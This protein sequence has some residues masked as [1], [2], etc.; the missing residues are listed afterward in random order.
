MGYIDTGYIGQKVAK[1]EN[2][3]KLQFRGWNSCLCNK[4]AGIHLRKNEPL[5]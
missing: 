5:R 1:N 3:E 4:T 2:S